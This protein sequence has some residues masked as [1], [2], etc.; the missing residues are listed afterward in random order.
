MLFR[1]LNLEII[2]ITILATKFKMTQYDAFK[3]INIIKEMI[4]RFFL[5]HNKYKFRFSYFN[6]PSIICCEYSSTI[7][8]YLY[9]AKGIY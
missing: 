5:N 2:T 6:I 3:S 9:E 1:S 7:S 8:L 4:S